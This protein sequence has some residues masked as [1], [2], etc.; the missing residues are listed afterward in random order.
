MLRPSLVVRDCPGEQSSL[1][2]QQASSA[3]DEPGQVGLRRSLL[4]RDR[5]LP[6]LLLDLSGGLADRQRAVVDEQAERG[7]HHHVP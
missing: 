3:A 1:A 2:G 7:H 4:L 6:D 5:D